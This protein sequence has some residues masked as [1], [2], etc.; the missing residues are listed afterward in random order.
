MFQVSR[1]LNEKT[2]NTASGSW[3]HEPTPATAQD[4]QVRV[5]EEFWEQLYINGD[6]SVSSPP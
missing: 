4:G 1:H 5:G 2:P 3:R 6:R